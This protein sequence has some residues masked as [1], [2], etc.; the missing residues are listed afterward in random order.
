MV[1]LML[2][3][4]STEKYFLIE[5]RPSVGRVSNYQDVNQVLIK[6]RFRV[7]IDN[8]PWMPLVHNDLLGYAQ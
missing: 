7:S 3:G 2:V 4:V 1:D 5:C 6:E 8:R